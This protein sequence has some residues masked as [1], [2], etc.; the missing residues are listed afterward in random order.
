M[1]ERVGEKLKTG[2]NRTAR[3]RTRAE[4]EIGLRLSGIEGFMG[5]PSSM[6]LVNAPRF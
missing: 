4:R 6:G 5:A 3:T 2:N 1:C